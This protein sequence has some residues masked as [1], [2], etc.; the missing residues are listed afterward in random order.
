[1]IYFK[2]VLGTN[3]VPTDS[4]T[5]VDGKEI[6]KEPTEVSVHVLGDKERLSNV[7]AHGADMLLIP[8]SRDQ[9]E[10]MILAHKTEEALDIGEVLTDRQVSDLED[11]CNDWGIGSQDY[12]IEVSHTV[13]CH[14]VHTIRATSEEDARDQIHNDGFSYEDLYVTCESDGSEDTH[15]V[16][17]QDYTI[18]YIYVAEG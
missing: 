17:D 6:T 7:V 18:E 12:E 11:Y 9:V 14:S 5:T 4:V 10:T 2:H 1:M 8:F 15:E 13:T 3:W 16:T